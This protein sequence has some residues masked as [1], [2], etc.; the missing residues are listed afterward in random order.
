[1]SVLAL[2]IATTTGWAF[3]DAGEKPQHGTFTC[4]STGEDLGRFGAAYRGFLT[5]LIRERR[6]KLVVFEAPILPPPKFD[7]AKGRVVQFTN[8]TTVRKLNGLLMVTELVAGDEGVRCEEITAGQWRHAFLGQSYPHGGKS[9]DLKRAAIA[10]CRQMKWEPNGPDDA[11]ALGIWFVVTRIN[12]PK[13]A[14]NEA[15]QKMTAAQ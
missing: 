10:A 1:M 12:D 4:P 14:A 8:L 7:K 2:D 6:P 5:N 3:G 11:D 15:L 9:D 13:F